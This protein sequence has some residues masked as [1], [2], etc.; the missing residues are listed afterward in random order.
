MST[1]ACFQSLDRQ[2]FSIWCSDSSVGGALNASLFIK[3]M[4]QN[5]AAGK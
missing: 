4:L 1:R 5:C 3:L 2:R